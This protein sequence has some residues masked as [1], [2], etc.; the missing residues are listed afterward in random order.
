MATPDK[1]SQF[2]NN[3][4]GNTVTPG[5][6]F[7]LQI[8]PNW[9]DNFDV[10]TYHWKFFITSLENAKNGKV[11]EPGV[12]TIIAES[13]V[14]DLTIDNVQLEGIAVPSVEAGTGTQTKVKF[15]IMEPVGAGLYDKMFYEAVALGI[16]N[17]LVMPCFLQLEFKGRDPFSGQSTSNGAPSVL[18]NKKWVWPIKLTGSKAQVSEVGTKYEFEAIIYNELAQSNSYYSIQHNITLRNLTTFKSAMEDLEK[19]LNED[20]FTKLIDNY[21]IPD[22]YRIVVD[23]VIADNATLVFSDDN[24]ST[25]RNSDYINLKT[26][27]ATYNQGTSIDKIIDSLLCNTEFYQKVVQGSETPSS[28]PGTANTVPTQMKKLWRIITETKPTAFDP[29]RQDNAVEITIYI[30]EYS[31]GILDANATQTAQTAGSK[32]AEKKRMKEYIQKKILRKRYDYIFT[33]LND[34]ILSFDLTMNHSFAAALSRFGGIYHNSATQ[35]T[36]ITA[37]K[38][39]ENERSATEQVRKVLNTIN[40]ETDP[41]KIETKIKEAKNALAKSEINPEL[42]SRYNILL[43]KARPADKLAFVNEA[44]LRGG[45]LSNGTF[46]PQ[47]DLDKRRQ[48]IKSLAEPTTGTGLKFISDVD[49]SSIAA[50]QAYE[51]MKTL[52]ASKLRPIAFR[53]TNQ[54]LAGIWGID[55]SSNA[56]ASRVSSMFATALYSTLDASLTQIKMA[57]KGDPFWLFPNPISS[58][59]EVLPYLSNMKDSNGKQ[60]DAEAIN[61]IKNQQYLVPDYANLFGTDNFIIVRFRSPKIYNETTSDVEPFVESEVFSGVYRVISITSKFESGKFTQELSCNIDPMINLR[62][63]LKQVEETVK[64]TTPQTNYIVPGRPRGESIIA[65]TE[66]TLRGTASANLGRLAQNA[67]DIIPGRVRGG[68]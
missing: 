32:E 52:S 8:Q 1:N 33:G 31:T 17:W 22:S 63:F 12:Q 29:L 58:S 51:D 60:S 25:K 35:T 3:P 11:L 57:I 50:K 23:K 16:G 6:E 45:I 64:N 19:K 59:Q 2:V 10:Y 44:K 20:Q 27:E 9:L 14:S 34:Q 66:N 48:A 30:V 4:N 36:G 13:G 56:G 67:S 55:T 54:E 38:N 39:A 37:N 28:T 5:E 49:V 26:K 62:D 40:N 18:G 61:F 46:Q 42:K 65:E 41:R 7:R 53:E 43:D 24:K 15:D 47:E 21:S 68:G